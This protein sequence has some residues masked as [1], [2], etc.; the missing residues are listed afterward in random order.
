MQAYT[1][2]FADKLTDQPHDDAAM[3]DALDQLPEVAAE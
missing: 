1:D 3:Q 2:Y